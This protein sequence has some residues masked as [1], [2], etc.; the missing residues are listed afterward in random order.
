MA[1]AENQEINCC[2]GII[3]RSGN[4]AQV[5]NTNNCRVTGL[6]NLEL[7]CSFHML[8]QWQEVPPNVQPNGSKSMDL[9]L[10]PNPH[11]YL[12]RAR[13]LKSR[14]CCCWCW[15]IT[16]ILEGIWFFIFD[17]IF[18][19]MGFVQR[20]LSGSWTPSYFDRVIICSYHLNIYIN[21]HKLWI[22]MSTIFK[23]CKSNV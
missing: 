22:M 20:Y 8:Q 4:L 3:M 1:K 10:Y 13:V 12:D 14:Y 15:I 23:W 18:E 11:Y 19:I 6:H 17:F 9:C 16:T 2:S 21:I 5:T 7:N